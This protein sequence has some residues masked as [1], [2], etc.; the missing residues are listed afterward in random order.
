[1]RCLAIL[2][3]V[4]KFQP[5]ARDHAHRAST[6]QLARDRTCCHDRRILIFRRCDWRYKCLAAAI[7]IHLILGDI[8]MRA[9]KL[10]AIG[11]LFG[12]SLGVSSVVT[13]QE[14]KTFLTQATAQKMAAACE[15]KAKA[16]GWKII[17]A[18][19]D[20]GGVLK[21]F[22]RMDDSFLISVEISQMKANTSAGIPFSSR[23]FGEIAQAVKGIEFTPRT[24]T[25]P[26]G[27]PIVTASGRHIGGIGVSGASGDQDEACAQAALD[28]V[29]DLLK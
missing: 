12:L 25:F 24:A 27:L 1:M 10:L 6:S 20:D 13:A 4:L 22:T 19:V 16:E 9:A 21:H 3:S 7:S 23:K 14:S 2:L 17:I 26:G 11:G 28:A 8:Q 18:I 5:K 15:A 29:K